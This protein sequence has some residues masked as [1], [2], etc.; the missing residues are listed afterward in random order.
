[1]EKQ[2]LY[3]ITI[4]GIIFI[5]LSMMGVLKPS[6]PVVEIATDIACDLTDDKVCEQIKDVN[7]LGN[8]SGNRSKSLCEQIKDLIVSGR[9]S[10]KFFKKL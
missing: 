5:S 3:I 8:L 10:G 9:F 7:K 6:N 4:I 2:I 1:M